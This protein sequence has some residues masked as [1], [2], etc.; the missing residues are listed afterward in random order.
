MLLYTR[1]FNVSRSV[2]CLL[3]MHVSKFPPFVLNRVPGL[4]GHSGSLYPKT[5]N[6]SAVEGNMTP[7]RADHKNAIRHS[8][9]W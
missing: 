4:P 1:S 9:D 8:S 3:G 2:Q 7:K 5:G 6:V